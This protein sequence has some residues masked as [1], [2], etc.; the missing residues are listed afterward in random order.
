MR[1]GKMATVYS[2][3]IEFPNVLGIFEEPKE[4]NWYLN[5]VFGFEFTHNSNIEI[6]S[7][8][9]I[10]ALTYTP[11]NPFIFYFLTSLHSSFIFHNFIFTYILNYPHSKFHLFFKNKGTQGNYSG[12]AVCA[13]NLDC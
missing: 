7:Y 2:D 5:R 8:L 6:I 11:Y 4:L 13:P 3:C 1:V 12:Q 10:S 9:I